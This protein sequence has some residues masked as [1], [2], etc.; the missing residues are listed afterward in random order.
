MV[1]IMLMANP[2][3]SHNLTFTS[4]RTEISR[5]KPQHNV[6]WGMVNS[7][8]NFNRNRF[9]IYVKS[10]EVRIKR[11]LICITKFQTLDK[12][13]INR[14]F[15]QILSDL[16]EQPESRTVPLAARWSNWAMDLTEQQGHLVSQ[17]V[18][19]SWTRF[20]L[21]VSES[22]A[23]AAAVVLKQWSRFISSYWLNQPLCCTDRLAEPTALF[24]CACEI[25]D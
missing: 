8:M 21:C 4:V 6:L 10:I 22:H 2:L 11:G 18:S 23:A 12:L 24:F 9:S 15:K 14:S 17:S 3:G 13:K 7:K 16:E 20:L 19:D 1:V 25:I 5:R